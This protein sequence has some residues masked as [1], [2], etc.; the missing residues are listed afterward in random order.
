[1][2]Q[3]APELLSREFNEPRTYESVL[4]AIAT[5]YVTPNEIAQQVGLSGANRV[6]PYLNA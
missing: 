4:R 2:F 1:L 6:G 5:G 3:E